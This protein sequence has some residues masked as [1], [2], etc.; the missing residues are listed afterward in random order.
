MDC[1]FKNSCHVMRSQVCMPYGQSY[2]LM[3]YVALFFPL[4]VSKVFIAIDYILV[5]SVVHTSITR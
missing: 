4:H 3:H 1:G 2:I 5:F